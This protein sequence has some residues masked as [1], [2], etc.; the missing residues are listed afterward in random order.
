LF[1]DQAGGDLHLTHQS[2]C[3]D[4]GNSEI[5]GLTALDFEGDPRVASTDVD[6]GADEAYYHLYHMGKV[7]PGQSI[8]IRLIGWPGAEAKLFL[9]SG[10]K[11]PP[12]PT[13]FGDVFLEQ[14]VT[15]IY[16]NVIPPSGVLDHAATVPVWWP[17]G[18]VYPFQAFVGRVYWPRSR[19]TNSMILA[20][21]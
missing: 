3:C 19:L 13:I 21:E 9:G 10:I 15:L 2:P 16:V 17:P 4:S 7:I 18:E 1:V 20:V 12:L 5:P 14:P 8:D 6:M 11:D